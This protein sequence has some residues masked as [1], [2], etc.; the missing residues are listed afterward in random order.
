MNARVRR[1]MVAGITFLVLLALGAGVAFV[2]T[3]A[4]GISSTASD[5]PVE[6]S[7][8]ASVA[9]AVPPPLFT[10]IGYPSTPRVDL[11]VA[12]LTDAVADSARTDGTATLTVSFE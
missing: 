3:D 12:E 7:R 5:V 4:L 8:V 6:T 11:A 2:L 9:E 10:G 1:P